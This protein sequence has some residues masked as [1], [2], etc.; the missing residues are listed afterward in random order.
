ML[1]RWLRRQYPDLE[2]DD[3]WLERP[4]T[5]ALQVLEHAE[6]IYLSGMSSSPPHWR[7]TRLGADGRGVRC[8]YC[9]AKSPM[10]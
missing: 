2:A 8:G 4:V 5:E 1:V 6:L 3:W 7:A 9:L 10:S